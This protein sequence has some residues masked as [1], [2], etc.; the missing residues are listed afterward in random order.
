MRGMSFN[1]FAVY[2]G[3]A[4]IVTFFTVPLIWLFTPLGA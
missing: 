2:L 3:I 1:R 4:V